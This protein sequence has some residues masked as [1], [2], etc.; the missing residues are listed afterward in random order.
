MLLTDLADTFP[1][2]ETLFSKSPLSVL[3]RKMPTGFTK[4]QV[5]RLAI[6]NPVEPFIPLGDISHQLRYS[7]MPVDEVG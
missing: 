5:F 4:N 7:G 6:F 3:F 1:I 2:F